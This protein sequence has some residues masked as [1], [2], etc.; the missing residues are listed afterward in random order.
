MSHRFAGHA[1]DKPSE[2]RLVVLQ[3]QNQETIVCSPP[4]SRTLAPT[5]MIVVTENGERERNLELSLL[6]ILLPTSP[7]DQ[8]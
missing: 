3:P 8:Y 4:P 5:I 7:I 1:P 2:R 6:R